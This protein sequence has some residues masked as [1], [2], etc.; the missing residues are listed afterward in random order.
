MG[1]M[2]R[3]LAIAA[4]LAVVL[5]AQAV[6]AAIGAYLYADIHNTLLHNGHWTS[7]KLALAKRVMGAFNYVNSRQTLAHECLDLGRWHGYQEVL[8]H[9]PLPLGEVSFRFQLQ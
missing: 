3:P 7:G 9:E 8:Y 6:L 4:L 5:A 1:L 2:R